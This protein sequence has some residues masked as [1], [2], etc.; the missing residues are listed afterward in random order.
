MLQD[1]DD[2]VAALEPE[3][4][5]ARDSIRAKAQGRIEGRHWAE[6]ESDGRLDNDI[7]QSIACIAENMPCM[8]LACRRAMNALCCSAVRSLCNW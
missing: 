8:S 5:K 2:A 3:H 7:L 6:H 1:E 4:H